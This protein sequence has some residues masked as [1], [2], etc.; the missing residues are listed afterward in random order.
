MPILSMQSSLFTADFGFMK[1]IQGI[2][3]QE[4]GEFLLLQ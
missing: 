1:D 2:G 3:T 4:L